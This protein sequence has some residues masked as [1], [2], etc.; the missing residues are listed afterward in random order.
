MLCTIY[1]S[2][3]FQINLSIIEMDFTNY[4]FKFFLNYVIF[5]GATFKFWKD[6]K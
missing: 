1:V 4:L 5:G 6:K 3:N 2:T